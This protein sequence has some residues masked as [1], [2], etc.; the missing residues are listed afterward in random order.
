MGDECEVFV[1]FGA[2][3]VGTGCYACSGYPHN[4][5]CPSSKIDEDVVTTIKD[6]TRF[7]ALVALIRFLATKDG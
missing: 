2:V 4:G 6:P 5:K 1:F 3:T 7:I